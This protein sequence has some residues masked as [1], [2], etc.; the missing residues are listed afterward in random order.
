[1]RVTAEPTRQSAISHVSTF[2]RLT[3]KEILFSITALLYQISTALTTK[4]SLLGKT[5]KMIILYLCS[6][7]KNTFVH[8]E[9]TFYG[10]I[11]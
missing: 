1:M 2:L 7:T 3:N 6:P 5:A 9:D 8:K 11:K 10:I 4:N